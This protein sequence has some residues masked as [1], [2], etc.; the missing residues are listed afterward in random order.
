MSQ[1]LFLPS[2]PFTKILYWAITAQ[3]LEDQLGRGSF[4]IQAL[5]IVDK[6]WKCSGSRGRYRESIAVPR[7][8]GPNPLTL[9]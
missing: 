8:K 2:F 3:P 1:E 5:K 9:T 6:T 7:T 4:S